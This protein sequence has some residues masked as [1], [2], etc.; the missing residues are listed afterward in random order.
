MKAKRKAISAQVVIAISLA[1]VVVAAAI[2]GVIL[3]DSPA[4]ARLR[5]LDE[6]RIADLRELSYAIDS[7]WTQNDRLPTSL[8]ELAEQE[9]IAFELADPETGESYEYIVVGNDRYELCAVFSLEST[10][11]DRGFESGTLWFHGTGRTC[12]QRTAQHLER[13]MW[14]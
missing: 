7:Y 3:L 13:G 14:R 10:N 5:R 8:D 9:P 6:R 11:G 12:V 1:V 2:V 4:R